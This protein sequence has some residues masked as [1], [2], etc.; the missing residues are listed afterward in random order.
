MWAHAMYNYHQQSKLVE[1]KRVRLKSAEFELEKVMGSLAD[2]KERLT[3]VEERVPTPHHHDLFP[4]RLC[5]FSGSCVARKA[6]EISGD[7]QRPRGS[8]TQ[9]VVEK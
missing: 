1:P 2:A 3:A 7:L 9:P 8:S 6:R 4:R 5:V